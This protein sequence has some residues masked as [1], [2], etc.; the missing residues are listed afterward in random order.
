MNPSNLKWLKVV[1]PDSEY[2]YRWA[3]C[4]EAIKEMGQGDEIIDSLHGLTIFP[5]GFKH[6]KAS[7]P[8]A[9]DLILLT[10]YAKI[11]HIVEVLDDKYYEKDSWFNRYVKIVWWK[12]EMLNWED[13][14]HR[15]KVL[16]FDVSV[17]DGN[18]HNLKKLNKGKDIDGD[19]ILKH[20]Q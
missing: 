14:P 8:V 19:K 15:S 16:G 17:Y 10:Q 18:P 9:G 20:F 6:K 12:P 2:K 3:Y 13:L 11:T 4:P 5:L 1:T 7:D